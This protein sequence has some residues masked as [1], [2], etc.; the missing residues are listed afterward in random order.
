MY[1]NNFYCFRRSCWVRV[2]GRTTVG[3]WVRPWVTSTPL[4]LTIITVMTLLRPRTPRWGAGDTPEVTGLITTRP[5]EAGSP[6]TRNTR[7]LVAEAHRR[8]I[9]G[10]AARSTASSEAE[11]ASRQPAPPTPWATHP[12]TGAAGARATA[13]WWPPCRPPTRTTLRLITTSWRAR[14][15]TLVRN[16]GFMSTITSDKWHRLIDDRD[17]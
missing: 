11:T 4:L 12:L 13:G 14:G 9:P 10:P 15:S 7:A 17:L 5:R 2:S 6:A 16:S 3:R 1:L 8:S